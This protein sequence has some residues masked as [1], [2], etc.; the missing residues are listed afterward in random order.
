MPVIHIRDKQF[1]PYIS[2]EAIADKIQ[3]IAHA[4]EK[5]YEGKTPLFIA[6]FEWIIHVCFGSF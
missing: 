2:Q 1:Q 4:L 5:D 6:I 3:E